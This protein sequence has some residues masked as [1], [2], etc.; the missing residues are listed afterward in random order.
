MTPEQFQQRLND[1]QSDFKDLFDSYAPVIVG[2]IAVGFFKER[3]QIEGWMRAGDWP[4]VQRRMSAWTRNGKTIN[5]PYRGAKLTRKI[6]TGDTGDL[7]RSIEVEKVEP[8]KVTVWSNP[9]GSSKAYARVHNDGLRAGR[10]KG[11]TMPQRRFMGEHP[12]LNELIIKE[13]ERKLKELL[14]S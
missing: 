6:L 13:L 8:G 1:L 3:F 12:E 11:F 9:A 10:G 2:R 7:G 4:E 14:N 5:N